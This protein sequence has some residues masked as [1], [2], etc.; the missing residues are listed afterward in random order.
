M[1]RRIRSR[2][3]GGVRGRE[4]RG[5]PLRDA[6]WRSFLHCLK[7]KAEEKGKHFV[8]AGK[9]FPSSQICASCNNQQPMPLS[10]RE[11][12]CLRLWAIIKFAFDLRESSLEQAIVNGVVLEIQ[13]H[14][15]S[16]VLGALAQSNVNFIIAQSLSANAP[17]ITALKGHVFRCNWYK[18]SSYLQTQA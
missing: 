14:L 10:V 15:Q 9:Y 7:Y 3:Y 8:E 18:S 5:S 4:L 13:P 1:N 11:Y 12:I 17:S 16:P 6:S 2:T